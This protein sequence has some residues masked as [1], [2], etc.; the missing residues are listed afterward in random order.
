MM[1]VK[2]SI[3]LLKHGDKKLKKH[4]ISMSSGR[5]KCG[6]CEEKSYTTNI[7]GMAIV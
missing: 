1:K 2:P 7:D 4:V 3:K 6:Q 5:G